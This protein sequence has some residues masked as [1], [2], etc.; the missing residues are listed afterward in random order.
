MSKLSEKIA[1]SASLALVT[2]LDLLAASGL[3]KIGLRTTL[4]LENV[5][6]YS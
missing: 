6:K 1:R 2:F 5:S 4:H 3:V